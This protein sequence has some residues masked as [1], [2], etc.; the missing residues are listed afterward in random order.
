MLTKF[1]SDGY[2]LVGGAESRA[3]VRRRLLSLLVVVFLLSTSALLWTAITTGRLRLPWTY[4]VPPPG[5]YLPPLYSQYHTA[6]LELP[7]HNW[8]HT[9]PGEDERFFFVAGHV[10]GA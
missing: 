7:Q 8:S 9:R 6:E 4:Q 3:Y 5:T 2:R 10:R 1:A